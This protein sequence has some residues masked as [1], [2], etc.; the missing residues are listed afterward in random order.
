MQGGH[1][2]LEVTTCKSGLQPEAGLQQL[3]KERDDLRQVLNE[4]LETTSAH[5][6]RI[7]GLQQDLMDM[8]NAT[9]LASQV[10]CRAQAA[11]SPVAQLHCVPVT[12]DMHTWNQ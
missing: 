2:E 11:S 10:S 6:A 4:Q 12:L 3:L 5:T 8:Q 7:N 9:K 1:G